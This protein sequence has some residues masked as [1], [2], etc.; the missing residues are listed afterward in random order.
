MV[1]AGINELF[2]SGQ[3]IKLEDGP[4]T[5]D[6]VVIPISKWIE[7]KNNVATV[8]SAYHIAHPLRHGMPREELKSRLNLTPRPF[9]MILQKLVVEGRLIEGPKWVALPEHKVRFSP[10]E[11]VKVD[12]LIN[13]F[14]K[15]PLTP[16]SVKE[17]LAEVGED[18]FTALLEAGDL[19]VVSDEI[20]FEKKIYDVMVGKIRLTLQDKGQISLAQ[21]RDILQTT[22]KYAQPLLEHLDV[23]GI[24]VREGDIRR[25]R[26]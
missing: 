24:T 6:S 3:L 13:L 8:L 5:L 16:P 1:A 26:T 21:T 19:V 15:T 10:Y 17:C 4:W 9:N 14:E 22:R 25:L 23:L 12:K 11:Q 2:E 7:L 20:V 18:V